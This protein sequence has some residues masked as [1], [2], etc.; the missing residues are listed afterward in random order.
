MMTLILIAQLAVADV[1]CTVPVPENSGEWKQ[2]TAT[3]VTFC[4]PA[5]WRVRG[6]RASYGGGSIRWQN[7]APPV[8]T[9]QATG[10]QSFGNSG[11]SANSSPCAPS[12][13]PR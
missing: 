12:A 4:I 5:A 6:T 10:P 13:S 2:V 9:R 1:P 3:N 11:T 7:S 8:M